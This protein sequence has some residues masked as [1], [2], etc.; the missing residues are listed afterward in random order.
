MNKEPRKTIETFVIVVL[1]AGYILSVTLGYHYI[2]KPL[3]S[4]IVN[5]VFK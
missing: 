2:V 1:S 4:F 3:T 5:L